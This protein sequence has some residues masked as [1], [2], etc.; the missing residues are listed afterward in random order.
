MLTDFPNENKDTSGPR[1]KID[2]DEQNSNQEIEYTKIL[3]C[4]NRLGCPSEV[5]NTDESCKS[6]DNEDSKTVKGRFLSDGWGHVQC[7]LISRLK[8]TLCSPNVSDHLTKGFFSIGTEADEALITRIVIRKI[9]LQ[10]SMRRK[11]Y[12]LVHGART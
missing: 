3:K 11:I 2:T 4:L 9:F 7:F 10:I 12:V 6:E 1:Y 8:T 5:E